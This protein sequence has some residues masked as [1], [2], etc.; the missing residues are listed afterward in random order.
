MHGV[1]L[2]RTIDVGRD[3]FDKL[4]KMR[5]LFAK[6]QVDLLHPAL[7]NYLEEQSKIHYSMEEY[8]ATRASLARNSADDARQRN[9]VHNQLKEAESIADT[10]IRRYNFY[11]AIQDKARRYTVHRPTGGPNDRRFRWE[12]GTTGGTFKGWEGGYKDAHRVVFKSGAEG[13]EYDWWSPVTQGGTLGLFAGPSKTMELHKQNT[14]TREGTGVMPHH[15]HHDH[16][17]KSVGFRRRV[18]GQ[19]IYIIGWT[20]SCDWHGRKEPKIVV[21]DGSLDNCIMAS[22]LKIQLDAAVPTSWHCRVTFVLQADYDFS[23]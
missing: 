18:I 13:Y 15:R 7:Y 20:L 14:D 2:S 22:E 4:F 8:R 12:C 16:P 3:I 1:R 11:N 17:P 6:L 23:R 5:Q 21:G 9:E 19:P 10:L